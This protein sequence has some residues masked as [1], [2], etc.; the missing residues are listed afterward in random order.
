VIAATNRDM[1]ALLREGKFREDLY[2]R[3]Y[4]FPIEVPPLRSRADDIPLLVWRFVQEFNGKMGKP[5]DSIPKRVMEQ[6]KKY[7]WPGNIRELRNLIERAA[8]V[9]NSRRLNVEIPTDT[10]GL[11]PAPVNLEEVERRH[12]LGVLKSVHWRIAGRGGAAELLG[13]RPTTLHSRMKKL[14]ISRPKS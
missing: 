14:G 11:I 6:L 1:S 2:H 12:L 7:S 4:V 8:I 9:S 3:L 5:I 10:P 13:L